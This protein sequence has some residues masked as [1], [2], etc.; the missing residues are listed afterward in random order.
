MSA[1]IHDPLL[2][3]EQVSKLLGISAYKVREMARN[4]EI[5]AVHLGRLWK[6][7]ESSLIAWI[8]RLE[9]PGK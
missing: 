5:P 7:R 4:R 3:A 8:D 9:H 2:D 6:F 1:T